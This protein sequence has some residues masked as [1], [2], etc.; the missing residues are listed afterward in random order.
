MNDN[1]IENGQNTRIY[2][3]AISKGA[4]MLDE[5]R[6][7]LSHW[8]PEEPLEQFAKRVQE[9]GLLGNATA[10]RTRDVVK[11]VFAQRFLKPTDKPAR[12]L[13]AV[14]ESGLSVRTFNE[15]LFLFS[16]RQDPLIYD[17]TIDGYWTTAR[18]GRAALDPSMVVTFLSEAE[19]DGRLENKWSD[20]VS[21]RIGRCVVGM[22][23]D[24][25]FLRERARG[26]REIVEYRMSDEGAALLAR[27]LH[28]EGVT[29]S[30]LSEHPDW[31]LFGMKPGDVLARLDSL[32]EYRGLIVQHA[33]S[34][35]RLTWYINSM[36][37][38]INVLSGKTV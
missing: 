34:V 29:D 20:N 31:A 26:K 21:I 24:V 6:R 9:E 25:G 8:Q 38:L 17:Y 12:V 7:L 2:T 35:V 4:A 3:T 13:K 14:M 30:A 1:T 27:V 23:R 5:T 10:Y 18:R 33:G 28:E 22:L 16:A 11:R 19:L 15:M 37:E 36:E 32:G